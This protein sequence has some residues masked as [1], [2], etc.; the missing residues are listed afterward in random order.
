MTAGR[1]D[2]LFLK[3]FSAA[4]VGSSVLSPEPD[5]RRFLDPVRDGLNIFRRKRIH[6]EIFGFFEGLLFTYRSWPRH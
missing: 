1:Y 4:P 6:L 5:L 3:Q 2:L